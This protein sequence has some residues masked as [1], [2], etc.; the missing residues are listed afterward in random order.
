MDED[1]NADV[2]LMTAL[3]LEREALLKYIGPTQ[4]SKAKG[5]QYH[6]MRVGPYEVVVC[7]ALGMGN[8]QSGIMA[9]EAIG[10]WNPSHIILTGYVGGVKKKNERFLGDVLV[11]DQ[12][13]GYE[14]GK[15]K[16]EGLERRYQAYRPNKILLD[17]AKSLSPKTWALAIETPRPDGTSGREVPR[18]HFGTVASGEKVVTAPDLI[19]DLRSDWAELI[20]VDMESLGVALTA[21]QS[22][23][24]PG[25]LV[26]KGI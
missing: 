15:Q 21:Y 9:T 8:V 2:V 3:P 14:L 12:V 23:Q 17:A 4:E 11:P 5:R 10:I 6:R 7:S 1:N 16:P 25:F 13:V 18:A 26:V 19:Q 24:A 22:E 20:G